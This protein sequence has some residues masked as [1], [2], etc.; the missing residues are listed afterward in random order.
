MIGKESCTGQ[1]E[2]VLPSNSTKS[3]VQR[4]AL[5]ADVTDSLTAT[6]EL[7][8]YLNQ[9]CNMEEDVTSYWKTNGRNFPTLQKIA[10]KILC[11]QAS[12]SASERNFSSAGFVL[13]ARRSLLHP[14]NVDAILFIHCNSVM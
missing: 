4:F 11:I 3:K 1:V 10:R 8:R 9:N 14:D 7:G 12:S 13:N 2:A 5:W 6:D